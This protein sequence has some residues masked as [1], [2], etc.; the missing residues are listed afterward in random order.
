M[1]RNGPHEYVEYMLSTL[2]V[3][4]GV[5]TGLLLLLALIVRLSARPTSVA[6]GSATG[7]RPSSWVVDADRPHP[8][9]WSAPMTA[10]SE[11]PAVR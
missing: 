11:I 1:T 3:I 2:L 4:G 7:R 10:T 6:R 8:D 9:V 5:L